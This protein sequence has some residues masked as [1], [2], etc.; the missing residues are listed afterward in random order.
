MSDEAHHRRVG[1]LL[2][3]AAPLAFIGI[4][5]LTAVP[6]DAA[7]FRKCPR[8][9]EWTLKVKGATCKQGAALRRNI[10]RHIDKASED[11]LAKEFVFGFTVR[12][13]GKLMSCEWE[14]LYQ[15]RCYYKYSSDRLP[16]FIFHRNSVR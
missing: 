3:L 9:H 11:Q 15:M 2:I 14:S 6:A 13:F 4:A 7:K 1:L 12:S 16:L 8:H 5:C 10:N